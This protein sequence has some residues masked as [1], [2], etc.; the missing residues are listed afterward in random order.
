MLTTCFSMLTT[1]KLCRN[2]LVQWTTKDAGTPTV[3]YGT[4]A[5]SLT[6]NTTGNTSTYTRR[7]IQRYNVCE[8]AACMH[9]CQPACCL[10]FAEPHHEHNRQHQYLHQVRAS[11][12]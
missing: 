6:M 4:T 5:T 3:K 9:C 7:V 12:T 11:T 2:M 8:A 1:C 10:L